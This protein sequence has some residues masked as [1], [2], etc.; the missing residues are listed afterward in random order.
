MGKECFSIYQHLDISDDNRK[1]VEAILNA[2][3]THFDP[4]RN[5][6]YERY[7]FKTT[8]QEA[9]ENIDQYVSRL[10]KLASTCEFGALSD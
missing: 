1:E 9:T 4:M 5:V 10:R 8:N 6:I 3:K 7:V 2:L